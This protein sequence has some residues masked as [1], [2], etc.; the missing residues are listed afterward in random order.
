VITDD[1]VS[2]LYLNEIKERLLERGMYGGKIVFPAGEANKNL[3]TVEG[4]YRQLIDMNL[5]RGGFIIALGGGVCGD[6]AGLSARNTVC[7]NPHDF[8]CSGRFKRRRENGR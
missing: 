1:N 5:D 4:F 2:A 8:A 3:L 6:M 7:S